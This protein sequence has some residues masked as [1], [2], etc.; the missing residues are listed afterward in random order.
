MTQI[1][2]PA[3]LDSPLYILEN[4]GSLR[5]RIEFVGLITMGSGG[6]QGYPDSAVRIA[7]VRHQSEKI[8]MEVSTLGLVGID[9]PHQFGT[10]VVQSGL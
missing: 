1:N 2:R 4:P 6:L 8:G 3:N 10:Q 5:M 7:V 9:F